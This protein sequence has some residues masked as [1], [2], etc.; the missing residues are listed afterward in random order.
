MKPYAIIGVGNLLLGDEGLGIH[1]V[2][3]LKN[4]EEIKEK[5][6]IYEAGTRAFEVLE[7]MENRKKAIIVDAFRKGEKSGKIHKY[8]IKLSELNEDLINN[9]D[10]PVTM[11]DINFLDAIISGKEVYNLPEEI[12]IYGIEPEKIHISMNLSDNVR[13]SLKKLIDLIKEELK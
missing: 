8:V 6:D 4:H 12:I 10:V 13:K 5:A 1:A 11:H 3:E 2:K 7:Y 9:I